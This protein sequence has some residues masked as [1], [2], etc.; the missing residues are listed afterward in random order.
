MAEQTPVQQN[1]NY[2]RSGQRCG[3][4]LNNPEGFQ[5]DFSL[6][7]E[8]NYAAW[9]L[10]VGEQGTPH[11]QGYIWFNKKVHAKHV[12][13][14]YFLAKPDTHPNGS[15]CLTKINGTVIHCLNYIKREGRHAD[16]PGLLDGPWEHGDRSLVV[17][18]RSHARSVKFYETREELANDPDA[19]ANYGNI[20][21]Q[22]N[23]R[24]LLK[25]RSWH[26]RFICLWG[27]TELGKSEFFKAVKKFCFVPNNYR[28]FEV[29]KCHT[30]SK[31]ATLWFDGYDG[32]E[33]IFVDD[34]ANTFSV[35][36]FKDLI[37]AHPIHLPSKGAKVPMLA[38]YVFVISNYAPRT[39]WHNVPEHHKKAAMRRME[40]PH[41]L[42]IHIDRPLLKAFKDPATH[43]WCC[44]YYPYA[45][46]VMRVL[47]AWINR[48]FKDLDQQ[49]E[50]LIDPTRER[51]GDP[52]EPPTP[53][54]LA[55]TVPVTP[56]SPV[57]HPPSPTNSPPL[58]HLS[59]QEVEE[60]RKRF[61]LTEPEGYTPIR[62][63]I[64]P[65]TFTV[66]NRQQYL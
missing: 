52:P 34:Y 24:Q 6:S 55:D 65:P 33:V 58:I 41:G 12:N 53:S 39:W 2:F 56:A 1:N 66:L 7:T 19:Q 50:D 28:V 10:E 40:E 38:K 22:H 63:R 14:T 3:F 48:P 64:P 20:M 16:K 32:E 21:R 18:E 51:I 31:S 8:V 37:K 15:A 61:R 36:L 29:Q 59:E 42:V 43:E 45:R 9:C 44:T 49:N 47:Y 13:K 23:D 26:T 54:V 62:R 46:T 30:G 27:D 57:Y 17:E 5:P 11:L 4:T 35:T 25:K 60:R